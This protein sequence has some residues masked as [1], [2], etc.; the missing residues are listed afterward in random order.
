MY[1]CEGCSAEV[2]EGLNACDYCGK[3]KSIEPSKEISYPPAPETPLY[4]YALA[5]VTGITIPVISFVPVLVHQ[6]FPKDIP[7]DAVLFFVAFFAIVPLF[8]YIAGRLFGYQ[9]PTTSPWVWSLYVLLPLG[10]LILKSGSIPGLL[11]ILPTYF[12]A[13][14]GIKRRMKKIRPGGA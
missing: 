11:F 3:V 2:V 5:I 12:G 10:V 6:L 13:K 8:Y 4:A 7:T 1:I 14:T 9:W